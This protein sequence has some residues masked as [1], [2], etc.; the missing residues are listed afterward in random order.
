MNQSETK[1][2]L[3]IDGHSAWASPII[4]GKPRRTVINWVSHEDWLLVPAQEE[5][6]KLVIV[7][8]GVWTWK[9]KRPG[10]HTTEMILVSM[11]L[12]W[13]SFQAIYTA[14]EEEMNL[15]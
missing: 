14:S 8:C 2:K 13:Q 11:V 9:L 12:Q 3:K 1:D 5:T 10:T 15:E 6:L 4:W 7:V